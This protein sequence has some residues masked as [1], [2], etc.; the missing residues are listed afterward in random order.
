[1]ISCSLIFSAIEWTVLRIWFHSNW[2]HFW[3]IIIRTKCNFGLLKW[4]H[5]YF[6]I[7]FESYQLIALF[8]NE[9]NWIHKWWNGSKF[10]YLE[11]V[12]WVV[13]ESK[14]T[15]QKKQIWNET[16]APSFPRTKPNSCTN[17]LLKKRLIHTTTTTTKLKPNKPRNIYHKFGWN[18]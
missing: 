11:T 5:I 13:F 14:Q 16:G 7:F 1:M 3:H 10:W 18:T 2:M 17:P 12:I 8:V 6:D 15:N 4:A 9:V